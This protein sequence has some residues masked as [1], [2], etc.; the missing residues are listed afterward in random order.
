MFKNLAWLNEPAEWSANGEKLS[1]RTADNTDFWQTTYYGFEHDNGH[2]LYRNVTGDFTMQ[3]TF[4]GNYEALYD[5]AGLMLRVDEKNWLKTGIEFT[6][7]EINL[8]VVMTRD[9]SDWS[10][11]NYPDYRGSLTIRL[12]RYGSAI[13][14]EYF[15]ENNAWRLLRL[16]YLSLP[17]ICQA[18]I[19]CCS[20]TRAGFAVEFSRFSI[21]EAIALPLH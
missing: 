15:D 20:P 6:D 17:E 21:A 7:G 18:G 9:Y 19:M 2:F 12:T 1:V 14:V 3:V 8:S 13:R 16:G 10:V 4:A 5:Q 11:V